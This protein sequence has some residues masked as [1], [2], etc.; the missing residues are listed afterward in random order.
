MLI[1]GLSS[2]V[3]PVACC[4]APGR[5][6]PPP[7]EA[8]PSLIPR[9]LHHLQGARGPSPTSGLEKSQGGNI[10]GCNR[11]TAAA[12]SHTRLWAHV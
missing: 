7:P 11:Q 4:V 10:R 8:A 6:L 2:G 5:F 9:L 1:P 3:L 12:R